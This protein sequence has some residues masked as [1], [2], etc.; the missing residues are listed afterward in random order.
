MRYIESTYGS[1]ICRSRVRMKKKLS[2]IIAL[3]LVV[4]MCVTLFVACNEKPSGGDCNHTDLNG[5]FVCDKCY[6]DMDGDCVHIDGNDDGKCDL[7]K[8][9]VVVDIDFYAI[10][11]L[12][13][14]YADTDTQPGVDELTTYLLDKQANGNSVLLASGDMWQG[15]TESNNTK[16]K[17]AT[18][19]LNFVNCSAMTLGN[20]EFDW[21]TDKIKIN[22]ELANFPLLAINVYEHATNERAPYCQSSVLVNED[23]AKIGIIG[24]IGDCYSSIS[25]SMCRDVYFKTGSELTALIKSESEKLKKQGADYIVLS[26]HDGYARNSSSMQNISDRDMDWYDGALSNGYV[27]VVFEGHTHRTYT[28]VDSYGVKHIQA[29]GYNDAI[30][31]ADVTVNYA[32][33]KSSTSVDVVRNEVYSLSASNDIIKNL[34]EKYSDEIGDP[35]KVIGRISDYASYD[36][37]RRYMAKAYWAKGQQVWGNDYDI[38]LAGGYINVRNPGYLAAGDV[39]IK[40]IQTLF[41]FDNEMHLCKI[42]GYNLLKRYFQNDSYIY[43]YGS[44]GAQV[45]AKL[46]SGEG[47]N[48]VYYIVTD[49]YNT[50]YAPNKLTMVETLGD[51]TYPR[52]CL[53][54]YIAA[55]YLND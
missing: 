20:H 24:A 29:G 33:G 53:A 30:A 40:Q 9:S 52:D 21:K 25:A 15:S 12:H 13:G 39:T 50:D 41:P 18:E 44:Y 42:T 17:L 35:D 45:K 19:W 38:V 26:I 5:D 16:G 37:L 14:M 48:D 7:C 32:N 31:H 36:M 34:V 28:L 11:D 10:N 4:T 43:E 49:S 23:G 22:A 27:N 51:T 47:L 55:G 2:I 1:T 54:E 8:K 6:R 3:F 46:E